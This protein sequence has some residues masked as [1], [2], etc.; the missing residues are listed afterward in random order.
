MNHRAMAEDEGEPVF[1]RVGRRDR[2]RSWA[3]ALAAAS[4]TLWAVPVTTSIVGAD[5]FSWL[6]ELLLSPLAPELRRCAVGVFES[7]LV[8]ELNNPALSACFVCL[9]TAL[10]VAGDFWLKRTRGFQ[11]RRL[12]NAQ[13]QPGGGTSPLSM[14]QLAYRSTVL[15]ASGA[16]LV[17]S[18]CSRHFLR[19]ISVLWGAAPPDGSRAWTALTV[20]STALHS[21]DLALVCAGEDR[22]V[23]RVG[24]VRLMTLVRERGAK[25]R[26]A[27]TEHARSTRRM[28]FFAITANVIALVCATGVLNGIY[29]AAA[30]AERLGALPAGAGGLLAGPELGMPALLVLEDEPALGPIDFV[31]MRGFASALAARR[32]RCRGAECP[33]LGVAT[34]SA[35]GGLQL[36]T[37]PAAPPSDAWHAARRLR[38]SAPLTRPLYVPWTAAAEGRLVLDAVVANASSL[39]VGAGAELPAVLVVL[40]PSY[41]I[42]HCAHRSPPPAACHD[43]DSGR[44]A[45]PAEAVK[46]ALG[47]GVQVHVRT[48]PVA[49]LPAFLEEVGARAFDRAPH[50][51]SVPR[52]IAHAE[53]L[54]K[55]YPFMRRTPVRSSCAARRSAFATRRSAGPS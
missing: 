26:G 28:L 52:H 7:A 51:L 16:V 53:V 3:V 18:V 54:V 21:L 23:D 27:V 24:R 6:G 19:H 11:L 15:A 55:R 1:A 12:P 50:S 46:A 44:G 38:P 5:I 10:G 25:S 8:A 17:L 47:R 48:E 40:C 34:F 32:L 20:C 36:H 45:D 42:E 2:L 22:L 33:G 43:A 13:A 41:R 29:H 39:L 35:G 14:A 49:S 31:A 30:A 4:I 37:D 9:F